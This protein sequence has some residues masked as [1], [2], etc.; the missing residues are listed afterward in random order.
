MDALS[1]FARAYSITSVRCADVW[2][3]RETDKIML[4]S[5]LLEALRT[6]STTDEF[7]SAILNISHALE[8]DLFGACSALELLDGSVTT[9]WVT[10]PPARFA[11]RHVASDALQRDPVMRRMKATGLPFVYDADLYAAAGAADLW[12]E[13][14]VHGY[15]HGIA[16]GV[17]AGQGKHLLVGFNR[18]RPIERDPM[19]RSALLGTLQLVAV[20]AL[21][22]WGALLPPK[23]RHA[24]LLRARERECLDLVCRGLR[25]KEIAGLMSIT[26][27]TV[28]KHI[29]SATL[30]LGASNRIEA[31]VIATRMDLLRQ[32]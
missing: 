1:Q 27:H 2:R 7:R 11:A 28:R 32:P 17:H 10:N 14:A 31:A 12:E 22:A 4:D 13:Q 6:A 9:A 3:I 30:K 16:V 18:S 5:R 26:D 8:F 19:A 25:D 29:E 24:R 20:H 21:E 23:A 15:R